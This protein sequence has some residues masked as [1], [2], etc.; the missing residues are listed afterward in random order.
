[1]NNLTLTEATWTV[2]D[3][4]AGML[5]Q[6]LGLAEAVGL[7]VENK[8]VHPR[9]PWT[10]LPVTA[11]PWPFMSLAKDSSSLEPPWPRLAI[12]CGWRSIPF[13]IEIKRRS[14]GKT[15][16]VQ[17]QDPRVSPSIFDMVVPPE[18][19]GL[20]GHNVVPLVG[21][22]NRIN[23]ASMQAAAIRWHKL[24]QACPSPR[25]AVLVGGRSK[26]HRF[27]N[28]DA[29][30]L[31]E[32]LRGLLHSGYSLMVTTSRRTGADQ[33]RILRESLNAG[34]VFMWDGAGDNPLLGMLAHADSILV[35]SDSTNMMVEAAST[36][37]PVHI[38]PLEGTSPKFESLTRKLQALGAARMFDG[39]IKT[40]T[41]PPLEETARAAALIREKLL[42][43]Q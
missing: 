13:L 3:G 33:T 27:D 9:L 16:I 21:S 8:I 30:A 23:A 5:N 25:V 19:D 31:A 26:T 40:W 12:G 7:P 38:I 14:R 11:W 15:M 17:L 29:A 10:L 4:R 37:K 42:K 6:C 39:T 18:H 2:T 24:I 20:S 35:T 32:Q 34:H 28:R 36:G 43:I 41:Y 22:P 1:M